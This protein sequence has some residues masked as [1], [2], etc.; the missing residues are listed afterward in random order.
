MYPYP[1]ERYCHATTF[2]LDSSSRGNTHNC[3]LS[4]SYIV[5]IQ[6]YPYRYYVDEKDFRVSIVYLTNKKEVSSS[7]NFYSVVNFINLQSRS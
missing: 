3:H 6:D 7:S 2:Q 4:T 5:I 1:A